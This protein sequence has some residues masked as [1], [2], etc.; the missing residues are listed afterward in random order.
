MFWP[1]L[2]N[3][4]DGCRHSLR[5]LLPALVAAILGF[6][7]TPDMPDPG[8]GC[9]LSFSSFLG[10]LDRQHHISASLIEH[11]Q[12]DRQQRLPDLLIE[13]V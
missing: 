10:S 11:V 4:V 13:H 12:L 9:H 7:E 1:V 3:A 8:L 5:G 6:L 2:G